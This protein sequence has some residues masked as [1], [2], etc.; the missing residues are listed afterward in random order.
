MIS[1]LSNKMERSSKL[2]PP[3]RESIIDWTLVLSL[4]AEPDAS[5]CP[6]PHPPWFLLC[7]SVH[8]A[9]LGRKSPWSLLMSLTDPQLARADFGLTACHVLC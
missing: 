8:R 1:G 9:G 4:C 3:C 2:D 7:H 5:V 6:G